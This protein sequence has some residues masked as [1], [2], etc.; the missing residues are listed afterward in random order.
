MPKSASRKAQKFIAG[1]KVAFD[2][3]VALHRVAC[4]CITRCVVRGRFAADLQAPPDTYR[5][6]SLTRNSLLLGPDGKHMHRALR[7]S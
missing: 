6:T 7:W 3:R 5:D 1:R 4:A 2:D